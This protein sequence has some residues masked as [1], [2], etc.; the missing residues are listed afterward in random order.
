MAESRGSAKMPPQ[1]RS[2]LV[3]LFV[4]AV[5]A[6]W[7]VL[8][9][10]S[11]PAATAL[12]PSVPE[13]KK[14]VEVT[15][16]TR[17]P[18]APPAQQKNPETDAP[19][20]RVADWRNVGNQ[21]PRAAFESLFWAKEQGDPIALAALMS[22]SPEVR[23]RAKEVFD[24]M[25]PV[26][27]SRLSIGTPEELVAFLYVNSP[28]ID[29]FRIKAESPRDPQTVIV[30]GDLQEARGRVITNG[31]AFKLESGGWHYVL[32]EP[33]AMG[34]LDRWRDYIAPVRSQ[35]SSNRR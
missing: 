4:L 17:E 1:S 28:V 29:G 11:A 34:L 31:F 32:E 2:L 22:F 35:K 27:R 24:A 7:F 30:T 14:E 9:R 13:L 19:M 15:R 6:V 5:V 16:E 26:A 18:E 3:G 12:A 33:S 20:R 10:P 23:T 25:S 8:R 21:T